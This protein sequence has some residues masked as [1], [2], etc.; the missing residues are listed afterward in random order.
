MVLKINRNYCIIILSQ[1]YFYWEISL[2]SKVV[3][4]LKR[5]WSNR[6]FKFLVFFIN[7]YILLYAI[8]GIIGNSTYLGT[9][10]V[11]MKDAWDHVSK[12]LI[13]NLLI[14]TFIALIISL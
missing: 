13:A 5:I 6:I 14:I 12:L 1:I 3:P 9:P 4:I 2:F 10:P 7:S 11:W 8:G